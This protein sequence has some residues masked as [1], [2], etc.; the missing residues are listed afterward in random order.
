MKKLFVFALVTFAFFALFGECGC[1]AGISSNP[2]AIPSCTDENN[3]CALD[4]DSCECGGNCGCDCA[5]N[6]GCDCAKKGGCECAKHHEGC[7]CAQKEGGC[8]CGGN[9]GCDCAKKEG[10][11]DCA[12]QKD[13]CKCGCAHH[14]K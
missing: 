4:M 6:G 14:K 3:V 10:G 11:C 13:G 7:K 12:K 1:K 5:K 9:C 8:D 2:Q